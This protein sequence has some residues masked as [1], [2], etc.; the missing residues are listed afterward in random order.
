MS[1][2]TFGEDGAYFNQFEYKEQAKQLAKEAGVKLVR[3]NI[4]R[5]GA[6]RLTV[7]RKAKTL[8][9]HFISALDDWIRPTADVEITPPP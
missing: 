8:V 6:V 5:D 2:G 3:F 7:R 9:L 1:S 4:K